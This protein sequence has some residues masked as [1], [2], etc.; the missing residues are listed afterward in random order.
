MLGAYVFA[1]A[2]IYDVETRQMQIESILMKVTT[3][4]RQ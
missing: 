2:G 1:M 3:K 4:A